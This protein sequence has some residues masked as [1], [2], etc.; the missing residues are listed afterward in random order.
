MTLFGTTNSTRETKGR[1]D[2]W[3][4]IG[5]GNDGDLAEEGTKLE[6]NFRSTC[7]RL[8]EPTEGRRYP[9]GVQTQTEN[10][11]RQTDEEKG[12]EEKTGVE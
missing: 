8:Y 2:G 3:R 7:V 5:G 11:E 12:K 6:L 10:K 9:E 1:M 4:L